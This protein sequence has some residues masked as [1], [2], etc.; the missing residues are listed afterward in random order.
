MKV[1]SSRMPEQIEIRTV[2]IDSYVLFAENIDEVQTEDGVKYVYDSYT[3]KCRASG[4]LEKRVKS[5]PSV[6]LAKAKA[7]EASAEPEPTADEVLSD[8]IQ[9]LVDKG[10]IF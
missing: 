5:D 8:L 2:G 9:L 4:T 1:E 6:W 3:L 7:A 10:V